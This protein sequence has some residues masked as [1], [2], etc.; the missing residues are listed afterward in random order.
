VHGNACAVYGY[1][2]DSACTTCL[3]WLQIGES[4][5]A[6]PLPLESSNSSSQADD[7][8]TKPVLLRAQIPEWGTVHEVVARVEMAGAGFQRTMVSL[9]AMKHLLGLPT[10]S[11]AGMQL[12]VDFCCRLCRV[13]V[14]VLRLEPHCV[15]SNRT[16]TPLQ[17]MHFNTGN[18]VQR[19]GGK[20]TGVQP[21]RGQ[22]PQR[23]PP[24]LKGVVANPQQDWTSCIDV[25][26]GLLGNQ[27]GCTPV[28][29]CY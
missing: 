19:L 8:N 24:G 3:P 10:I 4:G 17:I 16:G 21:S 27:S 22:Q 15:I 9:C 5:W 12:S 29:R 13:C 1:Q 28:C 2:S 25:P 14:Q 6:P 11:V 23:A 26:T 7:M 20:A 18:K